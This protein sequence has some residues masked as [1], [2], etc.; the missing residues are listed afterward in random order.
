MF[1]HRP[2]S[3]LALV[4]GFKKYIRVAHIELD[5]GQSVDDVSPYDLGLEE[6]KSIRG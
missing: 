3:S 2:A 5:A 4:L 1:S 6:S